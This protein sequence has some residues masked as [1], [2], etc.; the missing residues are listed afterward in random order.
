M[1]IVQA[2]DQA[3]ALP[4]CRAFPR[5]HQMLPGRL[6]HPVNDVEHVFALLSHDQLGV[7]D[8]AKVWCVVIAAKDHAQAQPG[9]LIALPRDV[10]VEALRVDAPL[11]VSPVL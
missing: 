7:M 9:Q 8:G 1:S 6:F 4:P 5:L 2:I 11:L 3:A 10:Q